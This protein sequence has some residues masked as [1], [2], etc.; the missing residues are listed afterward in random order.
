M[1]F[2][3]GVSVYTADGQDVGRVDRVVMDPRT[4]EVTDIVVQKGF[5]FTEDKVVPIS[6][7]AS[8]TDDRVSLRADASEL[9][10]LPPYEETYYLPLTDAEAAAAS[11]PIGFAPPFYMYPPMGSWVGYSMNY[12]SYYAPRTVDT[13]QNIPEDAVALRE[14]ARVISADGQHV[15]NIEQVLT[16]T[17]A[18]RAASF[19]ISQGVIFKERKRIPMAWVSK[20]EED[21]VHLNVHADMLNQVRAYQEEK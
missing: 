8:A 15:G 4:K 14:G 18:D 21:E 12:P 13:E 9:D 19:V 16:E 20:I 7:I 2:K 3:Q 10:K 6:L 17:F 5:L 11:Y 1:Q